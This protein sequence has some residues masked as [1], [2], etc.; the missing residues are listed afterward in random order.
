[1]WS[2]R[3]TYPRVF[4]PPDHA[5]VGPRTLQP[6]IL[7]THG[8]ETGRKPNTKSHTDVISWRDDALF[9]LMS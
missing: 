3:T 5:Q 2:G 9:A 4:G 1:M 7:N 8:C 6:E